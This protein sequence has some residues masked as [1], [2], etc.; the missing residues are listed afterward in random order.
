MKKAINSTAP[1]C[2]GFDLGDENSHYCLISAEGE[3]ELR[4]KVPTERT[5]LSE[6]LMRLPPARIVL[7]ASTQS[8]WVA[9]LMRSLGREV[10][11]ANE[12]TRE[13][14]DNRVSVIDVAQGEV[15]ATVVTG[16]GSHGVVVSP[17]GRRAFVTNIRDAT[18]S[19]IDTATR[20]L[21][22]THAVGAAPNGI[23]Y[24]AN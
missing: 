20:E 17:D 23:T 7:E 4:G 3:V 12:G 11:V 24:A 13:D 6:L 21:V 19:A 22:A 1:A 18:V 14:P 2:I 9:A 10:Y 15:V 5:A 16:K 8:H